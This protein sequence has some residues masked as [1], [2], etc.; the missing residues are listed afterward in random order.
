LEHGSS[1]SAETQRRVASDRGFLAIGH[2][3][4]CP[5]TLQKLDSVQ[6]VV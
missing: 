5:K 4:R 6:V 1:V 3:N 2:K